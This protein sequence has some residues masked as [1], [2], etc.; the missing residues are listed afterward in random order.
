MSCSVELFGFCFAAV[1]LEVRKLDPVPGF[2]PRYIGKT[3][4]PVRLF[5][6]RF[7][8]ASM[9]PR[10]WTPLPPSILVPALRVNPLSGWGAEAI[11]CIMKSRTGRGPLW[12]TLQIGSDKG[13]IRVDGLG[14]G[15]AC[16]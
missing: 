14:Q 13:A 7:P 16:V 11:V 15:A 3:T 4:W 6:L 5:W 10:D 9:W 8:P 1:V 2:G 12:E